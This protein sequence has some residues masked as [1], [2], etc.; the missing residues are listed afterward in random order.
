MARTNDKKPTGPIVVNRKARH[1]YAIDEHIEAGLELLGWEVKALRAG[2]GQIVDSFV[3]LRDGE[4]F[5]H[6]LT[7]TPLAS[8]STHVVADPQ[9]M[10]KLL[11]HRR[12]IARIFSATQQKGYTCIA[13]ALH[14]KER[15]VKC[16]IALAKGK[17]QYDKRA[18]SRDEDWNLE[19]RRLMKRSA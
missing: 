13:L 8:A 14:W 5:L 9:R 10:R 2:K 12:E 19:K 7:I 11:L 6:G 16:E 1:D 3:L 4:A 17:K 18:Q 15:H